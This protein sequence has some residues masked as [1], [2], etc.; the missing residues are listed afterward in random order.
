M[1]V[2][3]D[4]I[5]FILFLLMYISATF[6][7]LVARVGFSL[8]KPLFV[9]L[10]LVTI[11]NFKDTRKDD[12][13]IW[14][15]VCLVAYPLIVTWIAIIPNGGINQE[16]IYTI[17]ANLLPLCICFIIISY[18]KSDQNENRIRIFLFSAFLIIIIRS[19]TAINA[20]IMVPGI[21]RNN[22]SGMYN[23]I[24]EFRL[25]GAGSYEFINGLVFLVFPIL[26]VIRNRVRLIVKIILALSCFLALMAIIYTAWSTALIF[27]ILLLLIGLSPKN[28]KY[29][30]L[31]YGF[32]LCAISVI[33]INP[34]S[35]FTFM[36]SIFKNNVEFYAKVIDI[37]K[38]LLEDRA[39]GQVLGRQNLYL[40]SLEVFV[41]NPIFGD[42]KEK[43]GGHAFWLDHLASFGIIGTIPLLIA[44]VSIIVKSSEF[45]PD[46]YRPSHYLNAAAFFIFG[47]VKNIVGYEFVIFL[48]VIG[49]LLVCNLD[50]QKLQHKRR[51]FEKI[52]YFLGNQIWRKFSEKY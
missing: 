29:L 44:Y 33:A 17:V 1:T 51:A 32:F 36:E 37:K 43:A 48:C 19:L 2:K 10:V 46:G 35:I 8:L 18:F 27:F 20:E 47:C 9:L 5:L 34:D 15:V 13:L 6:P 14:F 21:A 25:L 39:S 7:M 50:N 4:N 31:Y 28:P 49:P 42:I 24:T 30:L 45:V 40:Q 38:S 26:Y 3:K 12:P 23:D 52:E 11:Y 41:S 16:I 22:A